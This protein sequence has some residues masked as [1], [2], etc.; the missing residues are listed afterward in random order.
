MNPVIEEFLEELERR[1]SAED[2]HH[3]LYYIPKSYQEEEIED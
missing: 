3:S 1:E 2:M